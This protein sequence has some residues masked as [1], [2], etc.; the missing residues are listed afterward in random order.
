[1]DTKE[2]SSATDEGIL[3]IERYLSRLDQLDDIVFAPL[4][5]QAELLRIEVKGR[6]G[7]VVHIEV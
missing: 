4:E 7:V 2:C 5:G 3:R 1:M 6:S